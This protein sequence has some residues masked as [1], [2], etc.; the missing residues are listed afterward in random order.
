MTDTD[1]HRAVVAFV[2][3][4]QRFGLDVGRVERV[5]PVLAVSA[6]PSA[7]AIVVGVINVRGSVIP[8]V[9]LR[10]RFG[11]SAR[12]HELRDHLLLV[13]TPQRRLAL[14]VDEVN[15]VVDVASNAMARPNDVVPG[16]GH[17]AGI[18]ALPDGLLFI[19]DLDALLSLEEEGQLS[20]AL[21]EV[22]A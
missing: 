15:G 16:L 22:G 6:L 2:L 13:R 7:P 20:R 14:P 17:L 8:V 3:G 18:V 11:M 10:R 12:S 4:E 9:D 1:T 5:L 21:D 19:Q